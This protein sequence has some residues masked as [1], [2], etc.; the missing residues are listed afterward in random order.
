M[1][2]I[3]VESLGKKAKEVLGT[4]KKF[5]SFSTISIHLSLPCV[6]EEGEGCYVKDPDG[7]T[8]LDFSSG[9]AVL[10][11]GHCHPNIVKAICD[12]S[13][14]LIHATEF[15]HP[16]RAELLKKLSEITPLKRTV[17]SN[18]GTEAIETA[19]NKCT[20]FWKRA[21]GTS[22]S[23]SLFV[24]IVY[25]IVLLTVSIVLLKTGSPLLDMVFL[26][27]IDPILIVFPVVLVIFIIGILIERRGTLASKKTIVEG[28]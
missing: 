25:G 17:F 27:V 8:Y 5:G 9:I 24:S 2:E 23:K 12:Q 16:K 7:N 14:K 26:W 19:L 20:I 15:P 1:I 28:E 3:K 6:W 13:K 10:N 22:A 21:R 11:L 18:C 4:I